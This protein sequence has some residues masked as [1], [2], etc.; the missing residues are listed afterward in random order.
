[1]EADY[2]N[3]TKQLV[4]DIKAI[5]A[6]NGL[7]GDANEYKIVTQSF[8]YKFLNDK[9]L[10]EVSKIN[11]SLQTY[12][13]LKELSDNEYGLL[14]MKLGNNSAHLKPEHLL[15]YLYILVTKYDES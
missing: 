7:G 6:H 9:F 11:P 2:N 4:D 15:S 10:Y 3:K 5:C 13:D 14:L 8:L 1:M 12:D